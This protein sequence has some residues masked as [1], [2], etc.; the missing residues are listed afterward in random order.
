MVPDKETPGSWLARSTLAAAI[1]RV[2]SASA[3]VTLS[4][5]ASF[6]E[7]FNFVSPRTPCSGCTDIAFNSAIADRVVS[8][9]AVCA[10]RISDSFWRMMFKSDMSDTPPRTRSDMIYSKCAMSSSVVSA[11][12][13]F[14]RPSAAAR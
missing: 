7:T 12:D 4:G 11:K 3:F 10:A 13:A 14:S 8:R 6:E 9:P 5:C 2:F 1:A